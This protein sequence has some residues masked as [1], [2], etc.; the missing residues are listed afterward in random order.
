VLGL[1]L[2]PLIVHVAV[3]MLP[4]SALGAIAIAFR[5][6]W[7]KRFG[8]IVVAGALVG[9]VTALISRS[10]GQELALQVGAPA[11]HV[12]YGNLL[13]IVAFVFFA[14]VTIFWL[15]DRGIPGNRRR[16]LGLKIF[17]GIVV[18]VSVGTIAWTALTGHSG[19]EAVWGSVGA[20]ASAAK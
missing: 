18:L 14:V 20:L 17:A 3:V 8:I 1:P 10:S 9:A 5:P 13:P 16:P 2:H 19:A 12:N 11:E 4:L 15:L 6:A 7:S